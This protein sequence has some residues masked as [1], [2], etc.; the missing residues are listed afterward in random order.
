[1]PNIKRRELRVET[2]VQV[3]VQEPGNININLTLRIVIEGNDVC[4]VETVGSTPTKTKEPELPKLPKPTPP[5]LEVP[6][7]VFKSG[8][9]VSG[10]G[11]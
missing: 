3:P 1:M 7:E 9:F 2:P 10:F 8:E 4:A 6:T 5:R 11:K